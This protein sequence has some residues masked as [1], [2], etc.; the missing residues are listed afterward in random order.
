MICSVMTA[1]WRGLTQEVWQRPWRLDLDHGTACL[2]YADFYFLLSPWKDNHDMQVGGE[3]HPKKID[4]WSHESPR[5]SVC[6][7]WQDEICLLNSSPL[8]YNYSL[9]TRSTSYLRR[10]ST[11]IRYLYWRTI[12]P[13][14]SIARSAG[15]LA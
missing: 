10:L 11:S 5:R 4:L 15:P 9:G 12:E 2:F 1:S 13:R 14:R 3:A 8:Y 7:T 6:I